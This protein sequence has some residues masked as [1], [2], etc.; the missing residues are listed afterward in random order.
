MEKYSFQ[1]TPLSVRRHLKFDFG[2]QVESI[3]DVLNDPA[4]RQ[5]IVECLIVISRIGDRNPEIQLKNTKL[6]VLT[7]VHETIHEFW[8]KR[9][10][11]SI[12]EID[13]VALSLKETLQKVNQISN[14]QN[15]SKQIDY[16]FEKNEKLAR[17]LFFDLPQDGKDGT[18]A[19]LA[20]TCVKLLF[21]VQ[22]V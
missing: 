9:A 11:L 21:V 19:A 13:G 16:S 18:M 2:L 10:L 4:E 5:I 22:W 15:T 17:R 8:E 14:R 6:D 7:V 20:A 12:L 3:L 1:E